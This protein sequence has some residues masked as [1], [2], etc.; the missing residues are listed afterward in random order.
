MPDIDPTDYLLGELPEAERREAERMMREDAAFAARV[1][2][3]RPIVE[4]LG[5]TPAHVWEAVEPLGKPEPAEAEP[6]RFRWLRPRVVLPAAAAA[7]ATV[8]AIGLLAGG[9]DTEDVETIALRPVTPEAATAGGAATLEPTR[10]MVQL[11]VSGL[12]ANTEEDFYAVWL[13]GPDDELVSLGSFRVSAAEGAEMELP[14][15]VDPARYR[16]IDLSLEPT[17]GDPGHSGDSVL[18]AEIS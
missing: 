5:R 6:H 9:V 17:D 3:L 15:P 16:Y 14:L 4:A 18:R 13:L 10:E 8:V 7:T 12:P 2:R 11:S 1:E